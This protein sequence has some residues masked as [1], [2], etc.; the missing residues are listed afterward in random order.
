MERLKERT[1]SGHSLS[2]CLLQHMLSLSP[3]APAASLCTRG[4]SG[5][6]L[7]SLG[8]DLNKLKKENFTDWLSLSLLDADH[9]TGSDNVVSR[10]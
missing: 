9:G 2:S 6:V 3:V 7:F 1:Y 10:C 4:C 8:P 5:L